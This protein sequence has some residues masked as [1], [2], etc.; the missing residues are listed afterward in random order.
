M[1]VFG[2]ESDPFPLF[3]NRSLKN[4]DDIVLE[5]A[6]DITSRL[7]TNVQGS[8]NDARETG[9]S[10]LKKSE[11]SRLG[12]L[13]NQSPLLVTLHQEIQRYDR[14][15]SLVHSSLGMLLLAIQGQIIMTD[16]LENAF[17]SL[18]NNTVPSQWRVSI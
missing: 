16:T 12:E 17:N 10:K 5:L 7:P 3:S 14:L 1:W 11:C 4:N 13:S 2:K 8:H 15:L 6:N 18:L 9:S